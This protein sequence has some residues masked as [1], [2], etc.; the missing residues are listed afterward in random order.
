MWTTSTFIDRDGIRR[1]VN[2]KVTEAP[3]GPNDSKLTCACKTGC[4]RSC[5]CS[6][7]GAGCSESCKC[8]L[9]TNP[10]NALPALFGEE[11]VRAKPCFDTWVKKQ[12]RG[13]RPFDLRST[14]TH[15]NLLRLLLGL[16][17]L[18][19]IAS[20]PTYEEFEDP[21]LDE[22]LFDW[23]TEWS[24]PKLGENE[25]E[26]LKKRLFRI[27]LGEC[28]DS[29]L[30]S[31]FS[32]CAKGWHQ[33]NRASHCRVCGTCHDW[34]EWHCSACNKCTYGL[35]LPCKGCGGVSES[36]F[37]SEFGYEREDSSDTSESTSP[38]ASSELSPSKWRRIA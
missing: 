11:G 21:D 18:D 3:K 37:D 36:Y 6:K 15:D 14:A 27:A 26:G 24:N 16:G 7:N 4:S 20:K 19:P 9:C 32:F 34:R 10:L 29:Y 12:S 5:K 8:T 13:R 38:K 17:P 1:P 35:T 22:D 30:E 2:P 28:E 31:S 25:R 23:G 33:D